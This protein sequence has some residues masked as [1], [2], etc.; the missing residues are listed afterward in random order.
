[1][2]R[3]GRV[4]GAFNVFSKILREKNNMGDSGVGVDERIRQLSSKTLDIS[5]KWETVT[6]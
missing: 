1:M 2:V 5:A 6:C 4:R 3:L